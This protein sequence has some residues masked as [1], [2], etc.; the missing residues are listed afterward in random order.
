MVR[1]YLGQE[2]LLPAVRDYDL[3]DPHVLEEVLDHLGE[4]VVK[5]RGGYGGTGVIIC[6]HGTPEQ[7]EAIAGEIS[8]SPERFVAQETVTL[9]SHPTV[10]GAALEPR[11]IDLRAFAIGDRSPRRAHPRSL[12]RRARSSSTARGRAAQRTPGYSHER[13]LSRGVRLRGGD[14]LG[15]AR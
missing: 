1:F 3:G 15:E 8:V 6:R 2:P 12:S 5:P 13:R 9:S 7:L 10:F 4:L 11:H 14:S